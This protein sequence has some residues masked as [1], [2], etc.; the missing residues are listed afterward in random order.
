MYLWDPLPY[1]IIY[2]LVLFI[3]KY[4]FQTW[5]AFLFSVGFVGFGVG[6]IAIQMDYRLE[7]IGYLVIAIF[8]YSLVG[9][10]WKSNENKSFDFKKE[11]DQK[12]LNRLYK[13]KDA[14]LTE[15]DSLKMELIASDSSIIEGILKKI[16]VLEE[17]ER[18]LRRKIYRLS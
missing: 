12:E 13:Q 6:L 1:A 8:I 11:M 16:E 18:D 3:L 2:L 9:K 15:L 14:V 7:R 4:V 17:M 5:S 10:Y